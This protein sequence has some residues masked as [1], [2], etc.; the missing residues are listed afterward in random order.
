MTI[1]NYAK[2]SL[3]LFI[4]A[5]LLLTIYLM[6]LLLFLK[7]TLSIEKRIRV[8]KKDSFIIYDIKDILGKS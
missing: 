6:N 4:I 5:V 1:I 8:I 3:V 2:V 7:D